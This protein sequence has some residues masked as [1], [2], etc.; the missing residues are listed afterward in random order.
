MANLARK[1]SNN[2]TSSQNNR[3]TTENTEANNTGDKNKVKK[4]SK[5]KLVRRH[6]ITICESRSRTVRKLSASPTSPNCDQQKTGHQQSGPFSMMPIMNNE[7]S[8]KTSVASSGIS[9]IS[10]SSSDGSPISRSPRSSPTR[11]DISANSSFNIMTNFNRDED[12]DN[13]GHL[14]QVWIF[15]I[16]IN[17]SY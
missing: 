14:N 17:S 13:I 15:N 9:S 8:R 3:D 7:S 4:S 1:L 5:P 12:M 2:N 16:L 6:S 11:E 10:A